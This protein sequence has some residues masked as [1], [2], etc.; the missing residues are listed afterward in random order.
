MELFTCIQV[1]L[2]VTDYCLPGLTGAQLAFEMK[3]LKPAIP[4]VLFSGFVEAPLGS[5]YADLIITKGRP[6]VEF[7]SEIGK[8][9]SK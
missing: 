4:V 9:I 1:D 8:L 3:R 7:L 2:V 6:V 5:E